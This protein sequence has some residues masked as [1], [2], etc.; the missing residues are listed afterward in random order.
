MFNYYIVVLRQ[1]GETTDENRETTKETRE[2][3][4]VNAGKN[5]EETWEEMLGLLCPLV[6]A[7]FAR[8]NR[9]NAWTAVPAGSCWI[10]RD[11]KPY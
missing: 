4:R 8:D 2:K 1:S 5:T 11:N 10:A 6:P 7:G 3:L 9:R